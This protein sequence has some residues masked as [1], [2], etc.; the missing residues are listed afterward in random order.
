MVSVTRLCLSVRI[1]RVVLSR[2]FLCNLF[3]IW[4]LRLVSRAIVRVNRA[5]AY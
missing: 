3:P 4:V 2:L 1:P 5:G